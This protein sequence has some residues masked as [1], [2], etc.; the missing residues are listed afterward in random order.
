MSDVLVLHHLPSRVWACQASQ[1]PSFAQTFTRS[2]AQHDLVNHFLV[3]SSSLDE[4]ESSSGTDQ[5]RE[6]ILAGATDGGGCMDERMMV[7]LQDR[8]N[9][10]VRSCDEPEVALDLESGGERAQ[11]A[12]S[13]AQNVLG[14]DG[15]KAEIV[16]TE[17]WQLLACQKAPVGHCR[18]L[19]TEHKRWASRV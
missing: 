12:L 15:N 9:S 7:E 8:F 10:W 11:A 1:R 6:N 17:T 4:T 3:P 18:V 14:T 5:R 16:A 19:C 2:T 13:N